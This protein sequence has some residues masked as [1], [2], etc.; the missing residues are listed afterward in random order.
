M[1]ALPILWKRVCSD[2][3]NIW[4]VGPRNSGVGRGDKGI[5]RAADRMRCQLSRWEETRIPEVT[6]VTANHADGEHV[7]VYL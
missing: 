2:G 3:G 7:H 5:D 6:L 1:S 4:D